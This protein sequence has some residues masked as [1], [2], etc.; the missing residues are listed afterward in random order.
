MALADVAAPDACGGEVS[1]TMEIADGCNSSSCT[2]EFVVIAS[3]QGLLLSLPE[4]ALGC[5]TGPSAP[6]MDDIPAARSDLEIIAM[7]SLSPC[8]DPA[9]IEINNFVMGP[10]I[11]GAEYT[12]MRMYEIT[13]PNTL[14]TETEEMFSFLYDP[15]PPVLSGLPEDLR[16]PCGSEI[17][18]LPTVSGYD[19]I[20]G[21]VEVSARER[22]FDAACGGYY[23]RRNWSATDGCGNSASGVQTITFIDE[24][25]PNLVVPKDTT[26]E[27][28]SAIPAPWHSATDACSQFK[29]A[30]SESRKNENACEYTLTRTW[31]ATDACGNSVTKRQVLKVVDTQGPVIQVVNP[32]I[33]GIPLGGTMEMDGCDIPQVL[34][35][36]VQV[37]DACCGFTLETADDL[38]ASGVC[39]V[40]GYFRKWRCSFRAVDQAGNV[41][42]FYF[43]VLQY[44][45][46]APVIHQVPGDLDLN[47]E[48]EIPAVDTT[49]YATDNCVDRV[50]LHFSEEYLVNAADSTQKAIVRTWWAEDRCGNRAEATQVITICG[51]EPELASA[52][53]GSTVWLDVNADG[54]RDEDE[55]GINGVEVYLYKLDRE[56]GMPFLVAQTTTATLDGKTGQYC[57]DHLMPDVYMVQFELADG[58]HFTQYLQ[59]DDQELSSHADPQTGMST[60]IPL[61]QGERIMWVNA[62]VVNQPVD[63]GAEEGNVSASTVFGSFSVVADG[64]TNTLTWNTV[65]EFNLVAWDIEY[66]TDGVDY[67]SL[68]RLTTDGD[69]PDGATYEYRDTENRAPVHFYRLK[70]TETDGATY[71]APVR[72]VGSRCRIAGPPIRV[73]PNPFASYVRVEF[74]AQQAGDV[75]LHVVDQLGRTMKTVDSYAVKGANQEDID[76]SNLPVGTYHLR[77]L[78]DDSIDYQIIMKIE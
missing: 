37:S 54:V 9:T 45:N 22:M 3:A 16:L 49:V 23:V 60:T 67:R 78:M 64:C 69:H 53:I 14:G 10:M 15:L 76:M 55:P 2:S 39:H 48:D 43:Y 63:P 62:G 25:A 24:Q 33:A 7:L 30:F 36:D 75:R 58:Q 26:I 20:W 4:N 77:L 21:D 1:I 65:Q 12:F 72:S 19:L 32:M 6:S 57:F 13:A 28:G 47:C 52:A 5:W 38:I 74:S 18:P 73:F 17:P 42:E 50:S 27:C 66:A 61:E 8:V 70:Y 59:S 71:Y 11:D 56:V 51:F 41:S 46:E 34:M 68:A 44:D 29:V 35:E 31:T 40:F